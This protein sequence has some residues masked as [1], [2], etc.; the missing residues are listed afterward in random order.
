MSEEYEQQTDHE[1]EYQGETQHL[2]IN[3]GQNVI[4]G[5]IFKMFRLEISQV[6]MC[7]EADQHCVDDDE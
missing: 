6:I 4:R 1:V 5:K 2:S 7:L 3:E